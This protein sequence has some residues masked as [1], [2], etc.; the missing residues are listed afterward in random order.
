MTGEAERLAGVALE[1]WRGA[2]SR[3]GELEEAGGILPQSLR[4]EHGPAWHLDVSPATCPKQ[5][6]SVRKCISIAL[7]YQVCSNLLEQPQKTKVS[8]SVWQLSA[9]SPHCS[10]ERH[11]R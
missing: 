4:R 2:G 3:H 9:A 6:K 11:G 5:P 8:P 7:G 1:D 10:K